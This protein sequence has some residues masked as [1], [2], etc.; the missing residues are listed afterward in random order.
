[1]GFSR[2]QTI[3]K[4]SV[5]GFSTAAVALAA[6]A[7]VQQASAANLVTDGNF[8]NGFTGWS[9]FGNLGFTSTQTGGPTGTYAH[10]GPVGSDGY[11]SQI[12]A[13][14]AGSTYI[15]SFSVENDGGAPN[16]FSAFLNF[17]PVK[18]YVNAD[19]FGWTTYSD[20]FTATGATLVGFSFRQDPSYYDITGVSVSPVPL[21][22]ALAL[23][24]GG[25]AVL[26]GVGWKRRRKAS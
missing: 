7:V 6:L 14:Q 9:Q 4:S 13:T 12:V 8:D 18:S 17:T 26:G 19:P 21:P 2:I 24:A 15:F 20:T 10:V 22:G 11:L 1:M 16:D 25:M 23:F 5:R 3:V